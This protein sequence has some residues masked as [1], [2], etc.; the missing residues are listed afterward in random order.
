MEIT[1]E[2]IEKYNADLFVRPS[3]YL[4]QGMRKLGVEKIYE[5]YPEKA[6]YL[7]SLANKMQQETSISSYPATVM[8]SVF[9]LNQAKEFQIIRTQKEICQAFG[10]SEVALRRALK[11]FREA[12]NAI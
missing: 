9:Y 3:H 1:H 6:K 10:I 5:S 8:A 2:D 12:N 7:E 11:A 4:K